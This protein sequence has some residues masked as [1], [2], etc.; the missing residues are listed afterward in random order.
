[1]NANFSLP[2]IP[3][4]F[5]EVAAICTATEIEIGGRTVFGIADA[6]DLHEGLKV[7]RDYSTWIKARITKYGFREGVDYEILLPRSGEQT[8]SGGHNAL[9]YRLSLDMAKELAMVENNGQGRIVRRYFIWADDHR[10]SLMASAA[11]LVLDEPTKT[12]LGGI[13]KKV[14]HGQLATNSKP[15][16]PGGFSISRYGT[17][18]ERIERGSEH[19]YNPHW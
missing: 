8:G 12:V 9:T 18:P 7:G 19:G 4:E 6:S 11:P 10:R 16:S 1:M 13:V 15:P 17:P 14:V 2:A 5:A 3:E